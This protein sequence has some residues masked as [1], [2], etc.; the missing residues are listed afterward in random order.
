M[1]LG[2]FLTSSKILPIYSPITP[3]ENKIRPLK[4]DMHISIDGIPLAK[5]AP[6]NLAATKNTIEIHER[7]AEKNPNKVM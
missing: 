3:S 6:N 4:K 7:V 5:G 1:Y 2:R